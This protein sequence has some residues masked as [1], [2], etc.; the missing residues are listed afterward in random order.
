ML[1]VHIAFIRQASRDDGKL[2]E[3]IVGIIM[4][5]D[6]GDCQEPE[7]VPRR[8]TPSRRDIVVY[9]VENRPR[10]STCMQFSNFDTTNNSSSLTAA[11]SCKSFSGP[12]VSESD[13]TFLDELMATAVYGDDD[14]WL[15]EELACDKTPEPSVTAQP[16][17]STDM[18][19]RS[20]SFHSES[21]ASDC[22]DAGV[23]GR[24]KRKPPSP[25]STRRASSPNVVD[26]GGGVGESSRALIERMVDIAG[27]GGQLVAKSLHASPIGCRNTDQQKVV[28]SARG[29]EDDKKKNCEETACRED[30]AC[31]EQA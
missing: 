31:E 25:A 1:G 13:V 21:G 14:D 19:I 23:V 26:K 2:V 4:G 30:H 3:D 24:D 5:V 6:E 8:P 17:F 7:E 10:P 20:A 22:S 15:F 28:R 12:I 29:V 9:E 27:E 16:F 18:V 11:S